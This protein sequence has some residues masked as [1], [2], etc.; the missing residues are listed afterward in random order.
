MSTRNW[1]AVVLLVL[2]VAPVAADN[3]SDAKAEVDFGVTCAR[4][5]LWKEAVFRWKN[6]VDKDNSYAQAWNDL[7]IGYEELGKFDDARKAYEQ[8]LKLDPNNAYIR[9]NYDD[10]IEIYDQQKHS[11]GK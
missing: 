1:L 9:Q 8:A 4:K 10:F 6:A 3:H 11:R 2:A 7:G 5:G